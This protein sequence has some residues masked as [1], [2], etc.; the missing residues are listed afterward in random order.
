MKST[1][2]TYNA[3]NGSENLNY[4]TGAKTGYIKNTLFEIIEEQ[5]NPKVIEDEAPIE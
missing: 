5:H 4:I 1:I 3:K 2:E